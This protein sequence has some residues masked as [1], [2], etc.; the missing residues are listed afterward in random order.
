MASS[1]FLKDLVKTTWLARSIKL[2]V[3]LRR[4]EA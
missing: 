3:T 4:L 1:E 2:L